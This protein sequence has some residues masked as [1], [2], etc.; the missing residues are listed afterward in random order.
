[1]AKDGLMFTPFEDPACPT[2]SGADGTT[3]GLRGGADWPMAD[4]GKQGLV[5]TP[6]EQPIV[7]A[8][9]GGKETPNT[10]GLG[11]QPYTTAVK[12]GPA[13]WSQVGVEPGVASPAVAVTPIVR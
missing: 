6:Y 5:S 11:T 4:N 13:P 7:P 8:S 2:P 10:S 9:V 1:M 12:D 3:I